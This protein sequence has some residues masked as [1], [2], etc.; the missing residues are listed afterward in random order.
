MIISNYLL[1]PQI[2]NI[3]TSSSVPADTFP[4]Y[5]PEKIEASAEK[6]N[7]P[8]HPVSY[9]NESNVCTPISVNPSA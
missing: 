9:Y 1:S 7:C 3:Q 4:S 8:F 2:S 6:L 5:F